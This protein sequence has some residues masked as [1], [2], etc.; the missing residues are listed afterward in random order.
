[1]PRRSCNCDSC[2]HLGSHRYIISTG[3]RICDECLNNGF[4]VCDRCDRW[5]HLD[6]RYISDCCDTNM[7][8]DC[9]DTHEDSD[10]GNHDSRHS[11]ILDYSCKIDPRF[12]GYKGGRFDNSDEERKKFNNTLFMGIE[13]ET[14]GE[15]Y[16]SDTLGDTY[17]GNGDKF[18]MKT[19]SSLDY[20]FEIVSQPCTLKYHQQSFGWNAILKYLRN[21]D[22]DSEENNRCG[23]HVHI[24][25]VFFTMSEKIRL[26]LF[27]YNNK[28]KISKFSRRS[29]D[30]IK[31]WCRYKEEGKPR[32][33]LIW[34]EGRS[35]ALNWLNERTVELRIFK[36]TLN[37]VKFMAILEFVHSLSH[38]IRSIS[39]TAMMK[40]SDSWEKYIDYINPNK[41]YAREAKSKGKT[42]KIEHNYSNLIKYLHSINLITKQ[43]GLFNYVHNSRQAQESRISREA[44]AA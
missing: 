32:R 42:Q 11:Y 27:V 44:N 38:F 20:G 18:I 21:E 22:F 4:F 31:V 33:N 1:M 12:L 23:I 16:H 17:G 7:C 29:M 36:G 41:L 30:E 19:D 13:L 40:N 2:N 39:T 6:N 34:N 35:E 25:K 3:T 15:E 14:E 5:Y 28:D 24:P 26:A 43:K 10:C 37:Y 9:Y 8:S